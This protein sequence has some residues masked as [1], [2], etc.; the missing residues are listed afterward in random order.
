[1]KPGW[2][3]LMTSWSL[4]RARQCLSMPG[5]LPTSHTVIPPSLQTGLHSSW[6]ALRALLVSSPASSAGGCVFL[7]RHRV[8]V[9][10]LQLL[11]F[12]AVTEAGFGADIGMEKFFNI[13]CRYSGLQPH[14]VVLVATVRALK[15]HGGGPTVRTGNWESGC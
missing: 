13:K 10:T 15:M 6:L 11:L 1:M 8:A 9:V 2:H 7:L 14:V 12:L 5:L 4:H 3:L